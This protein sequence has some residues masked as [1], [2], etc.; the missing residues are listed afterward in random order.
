MNEYKKEAVALILSIPDDK[1]KAVLNILENICELL[2]V[3]TNKTERL[4]IRA[5]EKLALMEEIE[6][7]VGEESDA[8]GR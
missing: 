5:E 7:V 8:R 3:D 4:T 2:N 6:S 1:S